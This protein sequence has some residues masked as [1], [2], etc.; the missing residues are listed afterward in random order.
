M[1]L[2]FPLITF[3]FLHSSSSLTWF[4]RPSLGYS[5]PTIAISSPPP[6]FFTCM[7]FSVRFIQSLF[8]DA[9]F[10]FNQNNSPSLLTASLLSRAPGRA[11]FVDSPVLHLMKIYR[12]K[13]TC[14]LTLKSCWEN[15]EKWAELIS[16]H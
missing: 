2:E 13:Q 6:H 10:T 5:Q 1:H 7:F 11:P 9:V 15:E 8:Q 16:L 12:K 4:P 14:S 3:H